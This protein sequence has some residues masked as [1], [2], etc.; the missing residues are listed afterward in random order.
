MNIWSLDSNF[1]T[2]DAFIHLLLPTFYGLYHGVT[3]FPLVLGSLILM[4]HA[5]YILY[6]MSLTLG[7]SIRL[8]AVNLTPKTT[9]RPSTHSHLVTVPA[10]HALFVSVVSAPSAV[11]SQAVTSILNERCWRS[12]LKMHRWRFKRWGTTGETLRVKIPR[13][14]LFACNP[15]FKETFKTK[16]DQKKTD[17]SFPT[18]RITFFIPSLIN[19]SFWRGPTSSIP[20][21]GVPST[22]TG[23]ACALS[24][25]DRSNS[26]PTDLAAPVLLQLSY[27]LFKSRHHSSFPAAWVFFVGHRFR[28][29]AMTGLEQIL[30][31]NLHLTHKETSNAGQCHTV[32]YCCTQ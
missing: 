29:G 9:N 27:F 21:A 26:T 10:L 16:M 7:P 14:T 13:D 18:D 23:H 5:C 24:F 15:S 3:F 28:D 8:R 11:T 25:L 32:M 20:Y 17:I 2:V 22:S 31:V 19:I 12:R 30:P 6:G 1:H 4:L